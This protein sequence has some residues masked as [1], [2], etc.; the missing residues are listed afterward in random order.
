MLSTVPVK[1]I[2]L[3][4]YEFPGQRR[5]ALGHAPG[6]PKCKEDVAAFDEPKVAQSIAKARD[7]TGRGGCRKR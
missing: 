6:E 4:V 1:D 5:H 7:V 2:G 3:E